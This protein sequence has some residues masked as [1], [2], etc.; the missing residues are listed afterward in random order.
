MDQTVCTICLKKFSTV[1]K[2]KYHQENCGKRT[3]ETHIKCPLSQKALGNNE[4]LLTHLND[5]HQVSVEKLHFNFSTREEFETWR[6]Q[7]T[8]EV[9]Y[10]CQRKKSRAMVH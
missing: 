7:G 8:K 5:S 2:K 9:D 10:A 6:K 4:L 1:Y 3:T